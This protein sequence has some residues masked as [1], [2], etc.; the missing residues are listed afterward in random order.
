MTVTFTKRSRLGVDA[1]G[2][3]AKIDLYVQGVDTA[4]RTCAKSET[5]EYA[6]ADRQDKEGF[7]KEVVT[8]MIPESWEAEIIAAIEALPPPIVEEE[9]M[10]L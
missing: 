2:K 4:G 10:D 8:A 9:A 3:V 1:D 6:P 5:V 7:T